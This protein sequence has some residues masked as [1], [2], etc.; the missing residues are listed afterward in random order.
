MTAT[1]P[2][3][4]R[5]DWVLPVDPP[6][7]VIRNGEV[8]IEDG[9]VVSV[10]PAGAAPVP[11]NAVVRE[12][13]GGAVLPGLVNVHT[14]VT[15]CL[16]RGLTEDRPDGFYGFALPMERH[17][18]PEA[19]YALSRL[20]VAE[21]LLAG[22]TYI[23]DIFHFSRD[24]AR[25]AAELGVRAQIA[26]KIFDTDLT[27]IQSGERKQIPE[28]GD[29]RLQANIDLY[30]E[31]DGKADGRIQVRFGAH[32]ADTCSPRLLGAI[33]DAADERGAGIHIHVAQSPEERDHMRAVHGTGSI[34]FLDG[35]GFLG[36]NVITAHVTY[37]TDKGIELLAETDTAV[38]HCPAIIA[39]RGRFTPVKAI[40][41]AGIRVG[42]GT[43]WVTMDPWDAMRF[44]I[45]GARM[46]YSDIE[47]LSARE[48]LWYSTMGSAR[49]F[50]KADDIG[51]LEPGKQADLIV[52]DLRQPH[53]SPL[54]DPVTTLVY[55]A[56]GRD[57]TD[58]MIGGEFVVRDRKLAGADVAEILDAAQAA[59]ERI[60]HAEERA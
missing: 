38:A 5:A 52:V 23:N 11:P 54:L 32:A 26:Q 33:R 30:D 28:E 22:C 34:E 12:F 36:P 39:K 42:W 51:S 27:T 14:H 10:G 6:F 15:G 58:V 40:Y 1:R 46:R 9:R 7:R 48:A 35:Q 49:V 59:A 47:L 29:R 16:F 31:W 17:L 21:V 20:G 24:T 57:I 37:A 50:G 45:S 60:W 8:V 25:A 55:N 53:L 19:T 44:G 4:I 41:D 18:D 2:T 3:V 56:T 13:L 43:D